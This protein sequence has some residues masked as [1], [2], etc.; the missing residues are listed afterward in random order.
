MRDDAYASFMSLIFAEIVTSPMSWCCSR[1]L[2]H[3]W[4]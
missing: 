3:R 4:G 1:L 2:Q